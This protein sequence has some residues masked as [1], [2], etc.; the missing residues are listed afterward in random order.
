MEVWTYIMKY[1]VQ[2]NIITYTQKLFETWKE[3]KDEALKIRNI[4]SN[5]EIEICWSWRYLV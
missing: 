3:E 1:I 2:Y 5:R 4:R